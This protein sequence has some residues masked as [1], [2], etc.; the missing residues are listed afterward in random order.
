MGIH[1]ICGIV[2][3]FIVMNKYIGCIVV[4]ADIPLIDHYR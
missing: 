1:L 2:E 3:L 4:I